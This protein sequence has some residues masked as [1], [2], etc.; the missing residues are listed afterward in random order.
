MLNNNDQTIEQIVTFYSEKESE[1]FILFAHK[2]KNIPICLTTS[3]CEKFSV[4][5]LDKFN[6]K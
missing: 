4:Y 1:N 3:H 5:C 6:L 2:P